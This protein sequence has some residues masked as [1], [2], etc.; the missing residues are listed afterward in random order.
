MP[1]NALLSTLN[2]PPVGFLVLNTDLISSICFITTLLVMLGSSNALAPL[3]TIS[4]SASKILF[5]ISLALF[6]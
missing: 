3:S 5:S 2:H 1:F 4:C 6:V